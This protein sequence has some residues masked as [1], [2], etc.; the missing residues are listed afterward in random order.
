MALK[1]T[2]KEIVPFTPPV[3]DRTDEAITGDV[4]T[5]E[6]ELR[7]N[8]RIIRKGWKTATAKAQ[9]VYSALTIIHTK[10][11]WKLHLDPEGKR[12]YS[13]FEKYL[14]QEFGWEMD[15][16]RALQIIKQ[17]RADLLESGELTEADMPA[18]RART[19]PEITA[20]KAAQVTTD[21]FTKVL[22]AFR[23]RLVNIEYGAGRDDLDIVYEDAATAVT[24]I[25]SNLQRVIDDEA[26]RAEEARAE[27]QTVSPIKGK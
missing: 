23:L 21:Q 12:K 2:V 15:R 18:Q 17:T 22:N 9:E 14:F 6:S 3:D 10:S 26:Q 8:E 4:I 19:A 25:L 27:A 1:D 5:P 16:T 13:S 24:A 7:D 11:L 20:T